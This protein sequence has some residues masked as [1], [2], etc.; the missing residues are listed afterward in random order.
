MTELELD[1]HGSR[2]RLPK[3]DRVSL[4]EISVHLTER[5]AGCGPFFPP[6]NHWLNIADLGLES[7]DSRTP[8]LQLLRAPS[9][10]SRFSLAG[11]VEDFRKNKKGKDAP[12]APG[13]PVGD[14]LVFRRETWVYNIENLPKKARPTAPEIDWFSKI[15]AF[16]KKESLPRRCF[17]SFRGKPQFVDFQSVISL[18]AFQKRLEK[19]EGEIVFTEMLP[20]PE[21]LPGEGRAVELIVEFE[22]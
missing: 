9:R 8:V 18:R 4:D 2:L 6:F 21:Q 13:F 11:M 19:T 5:P 3:E 1:F 7:P 15:R 17:Y 16:Q 14:D 20:L 12:P 22:L 10:S